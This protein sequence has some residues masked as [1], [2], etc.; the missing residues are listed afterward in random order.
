MR[1]VQRTAHPTY[2]APGN[3]WRRR[4]EIQHVPSNPGHVHTAYC[5]GKSPPTTYRQVA[6]NGRTRRHIRLAKI[7]VC[8]G[9]LRHACA[10][11][12]CAI[13]GMVCLIRG[14]FDPPPDWG[15][16][17][18]SL[19]LGRAWLVVAVGF[20]GDR[21][22]LVLGLG[23]VRAAREEPRENREGDHQADP[24]ESKPNNERVDH[25][26]GTDRVPCD[27]LLKCDEALR[28]PE[29]AR[30]FGHDIE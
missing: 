6:A 7:G 18:C 16:P 3:N 10:R 14:G 22:G 29:G 21:R 11:A 25:R 23:I 15:L 2:Y 28:E 27:E 24:A 20:F 30:E 4:Q 17:G 26:V 9:Q 19:R 8:D 13:R 5:V 12:F 1:T